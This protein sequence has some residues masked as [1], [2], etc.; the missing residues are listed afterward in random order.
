MTSTSTPSRIDNL[1][2]PQA[3]MPRPQHRADLLA[4]RLGYLQYRHR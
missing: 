1:P 2:S 3:F 4:S